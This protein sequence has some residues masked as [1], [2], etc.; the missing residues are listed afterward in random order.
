MDLRAWL[1]FL[2]GCET[3][4][5]VGG[6]SGFHSGED[7]ATLT[8]AFL[9]AGVANVIATLWRVE[10]R[11]AAMFAERFYREL[12]A[13]DGKDTPGHDQLALA[14]SRAQRDLLR[15][16]KWADP[17]YWAGFRL[18]GTGDE[19]AARSRGVVRS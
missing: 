7:Y 1:I 3:G 2:S 12:G 5:G 19:P 8:R 4:L 13:R 16:P 9:K 10:D 11:G 15:D 6:S 14:L 18:T 17:Y